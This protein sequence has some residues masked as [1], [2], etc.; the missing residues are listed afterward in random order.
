MKKMLDTMVIF[1]ATGDLTSRYLLPA[2]AKLHQAERLS[3][4]FHIIGVARQPWNKDKFRKHIADSLE[5]HGGQTHAEMRQG[6]LGSLDYERCDVSNPE[7]VSAL[8][9]PLKKPFVA[10]LAIPS[11]LFEPV[12]DALL[13]VQLASGSRIVCEKPFGHDLA[14][15]QK[16]NRL[17]S[18]SLPENAVFRVDHF[19]HKQTIQN[20]LGLRFANRI[21]EPVWNSQHIERVEIIWDETLS[22]D[23]RSSYYDSTGALLDMIQNHLLQLLCLVAMEVPHSLEEDDFRDR[24]VDVLRAIRRYSEEEVKGRTIRGRYASG[25]IAGRAIPAYVDEQGVDPSRN[26]ET[27]AQV[28]LGVHSWRWAGVPFI[29]RTGKALNRRRKSIEIYFKPVPHLVF[30]QDRAPAPNVL[31]LNTTPD[32][33]AVQVNINGPGDPFELERLEVNAELS[34]HE[35]PAYARLLID[36]LEG[37]PTLSIRDDEVEESWRVIEPIVEAWRANAVPLREYSAGSSGPES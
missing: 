20:I 24:K 12:I 10:Y 4:P 28:T 7:E 2:L 37:D 27:F 16:L 32:Q 18:K 21:F 25:A 36:V 26:T 9:K 5:K 13:R 3:D 23:G 30:G 31:R 14:S 33:L 1:G 35:L 15:A 22:V 34:P 6:L 29:L 11:G 19:L 17:L 8:L